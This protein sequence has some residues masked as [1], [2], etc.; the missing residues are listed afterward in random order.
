VELSLS[1]E[2]TKKLVA[3]MLRDNGLW[4]LKIHNGHI[5]QGVKLPKTVDV[6]ELL[7]EVSG[8]DVSVPQSDSGDG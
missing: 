3:R 4:L 7:A 6:D 1:S 5:V 8:G 2:K